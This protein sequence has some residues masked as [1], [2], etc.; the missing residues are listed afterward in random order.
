VCLSVCGCVYLFVGVF[1]CLWVCLSVCLFA[2]AITLEPFAISSRNFY[3]S[4]FED[5][6]ILMHCGVRVVVISLTFYSLIINVRHRLA[7]GVLFELR[8]KRLLD[9]V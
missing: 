4:N 3:G 2:D 1:V 5:G 6:C 7:S 8:V 9:G